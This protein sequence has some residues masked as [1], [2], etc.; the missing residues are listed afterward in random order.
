[1]VTTWP[2]PAGATV[3]A[4]AEADAKYVVLLGKRLRILRTFH[5]LTQ[6]EV[7]HRA[8]ITRNY[9]SAVERG[10]QCLDAV[11]A[12][13]LAIVLGVDI[14]DLLADLTLDGAR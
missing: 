2:S 14:G 12:R 7:A 1:M 11:R 3:E 13:R 4:S 8:G 9:L 10:T 5:G 6:E